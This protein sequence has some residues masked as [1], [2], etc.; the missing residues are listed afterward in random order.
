[1]ENYLIMLLI[2]ILG[3]NEGLKF[4]EGFVDCIF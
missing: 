4:F 2:S 3:A 1:M